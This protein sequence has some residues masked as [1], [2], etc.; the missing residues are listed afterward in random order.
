MSQLYQA[1]TLISAS[2]LSEATIQLLQMP[3]TRKDTGGT[4]RLGDFLASV[5]AA[6]ICS[7]DGASAIAVVCWGKES[8]SNTFYKIILSLKEIQGDWNPEGFGNE[9]D[10]GR[11]IHWVSAFSLDESSAQTHSEISPTIN[12]NAVRGVLDALLHH[13]VRPVAKDDPLSMMITAV[14]KS[15]EGANEIVSAGKKLLLPIFKN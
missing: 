15:Q 11:F 7:Q 1:F 5:T 10:N 6:R 13:I 12:H 3:V 9:W 8:S 14:A 2:T 4:V